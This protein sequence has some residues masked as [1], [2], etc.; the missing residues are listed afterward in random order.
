MSAGVIKCKE[1][2][3]ALFM[4]ALKFLYC[5]PNCPFHRNSLYAGG[6]DEAHRTGLAEYLF[7]VLRTFD[8]AAVTQGN[9][10][11]IDLQ[12]CRKHPLFR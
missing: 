3:N 5:L 10:L 2:R 9:D 6:A 8:G 12:A 1:N 11:R 4:H 7:K